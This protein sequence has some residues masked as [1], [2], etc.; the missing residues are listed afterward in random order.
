MTTSTSKYGRTKY[1]VSLSDLVAAGAVLTF[2]FPLDSLPPGAVVYSTMVKASTAL[3]GA[4]TSV[5]Q[6][7]LG[8]TLIGASTDVKATTGGINNTVAVGSLTAASALALTV[9]NT[10]NNLSA[11]TAGSIDLIINY[12]SLA[13]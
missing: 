11:L 8:G 5:A 2:D 13:P 7:K 4:A 6:P 1:T 12:T 3:L 9:T 10:T